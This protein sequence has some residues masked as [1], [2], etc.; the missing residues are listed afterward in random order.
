M[1]E[2]DRS[3]GAPTIDHRTAD[4]RVAIVG[5][6]LLALSWWIACWSSVPG[7]ERS[8]VR[9]L[10]DVSDLAAS[11]LWPIMQFGTLVAAQLVALVVLVVSRRARPAVDVLVAG[12]LAWLTAHVVKDLV[13]RGR[14]FDVITGVTVHGGAPDGFGFPSGHASVAFAIAGALAPWLPRRAQIAVFAAAALVAIARVVHGVHFPVDV[15]GG[16]GLGLVVAVVTRTVL[17]LVGV[18]R[19][20]QRA[21]AAG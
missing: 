9:R 15:I 14:P 5:L 4:L 18:E 12:T 10:S 8:I 13:E 3:S 2:A 1:D 20:D 16:A 6:A 21:G 19:G 7:L 17:D 11:S